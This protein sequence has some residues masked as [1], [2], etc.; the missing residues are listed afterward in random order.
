MR[1]VRWTRKHHRDDTRL[2][3]LQDRAVQSSNTRAV[4]LFRQSAVPFMYFFFWFSSCPWKNYIEILQRIKNLECRRNMD[5][6]LHVGLTVRTNLRFRLRR[7]PS[8][9]DKRDSLLLRSLHHKTSRSSNTEPSASE[10]LQAPHLVI[11]GRRAR[12]VVG[13]QD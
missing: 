6:L 10:R 3:V 11:S 13:N 9:E 1:L 5:V 7:S 4:V 8:E 12:R 2:S